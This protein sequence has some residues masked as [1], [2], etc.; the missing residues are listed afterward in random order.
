MRA[1]LILSLL[2]AGCGSPTASPDRQFDIAMNTGSYSDICAAARRAAEHHLQQGDQAGFERWRLMR[3]VYCATA[4]RHPDERPSDQA[5]DESVA[6]NQ[7]YQDAVNR[8]AA[9]EANLATH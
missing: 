8:V 5:T 7:S 2:A 3:D 1:V 6:A 4:E 9:I